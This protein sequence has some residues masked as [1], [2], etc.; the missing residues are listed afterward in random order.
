VVGAQA[1]RQ[2]GALRVGWDNLYRRLQQSKR[3]ILSHDGGAA[4][5]LM[6]A[7]LVALMAVALLMGTLLAFRAGAP[8]ADAQA[9]RVSSSASC[10]QLAATDPTITN[11]SSWGRT[12]LR[13]H[14]APGGWFGVDVCSNGFNS[15]S[16]NSSNVSCDSVGHGCS[17]TNDGYGWTFQCPELIVRFSAWAFGD[18]PADWGRSG[19]GNAPDL[20]LPANHPSDFVMYRNGSSTAPVPGDILIWGYLDGRGNPFPAGPDG[21]HGG[22]IAVV[23]SVH[24]GIVTTAEQNVKWGSEDH[25][26]DTLALKKVGSRWILSGSA[27]PSRTLPTWRWLNTMGHSRGTYG[28]LHNVKN[29]GR[30]PAKHTSSA[31][32]AKTTTASS[33]TVSNQFPGGLPSL[34]MATVITRSGTLADLT[35]STQS[36]FSPSSDGDQQEA[37]VR[38]LGTP[39]D[40]IHLASGQSAATLLL[41]DGSRYTYA[42]GT[43]GNLYVAR[44]SPTSFGVFWSTL[45]QPGGVS[46]TG[47]PVASL[48]AGGVQVAA[49]G[50]DGS[51]WWRAGP[52]DRPGSWFSLGSPSASPLSGSVALAGEPGSGMPIVF[53][54]GADGR[55]YTR[56]WQD[57]MVAADGTQI[58]A[59]WSDWLTLGAQSGV[60]QF[61]GALL[62]VPELPT[63][64]NWIGPWPD[65]PLNV[66]AADSAGQLWWLRSTHLSTGWTATAVAGGP[67]PLSA[68]YGAVAVPAAATSASAA[69][70]D[71]I[72][73]YA[74]SQQASYL[75]TL[76]I[77][78]AGA[79]GAGA[80]NAP[81]QPSNPTWT[82]LAAPPAGVTA[83]TVGAAVALGPGNSVLVAAAGDDVVIG[84]VKTMTAAM[85]P[86]AAAQRTGAKQPANPWMRVGAVPAAATFSDPFTATSLDS[87]WTRSDG[88]ARVTLD[89]KGL[90]LAPGANGV[91][92][93]M[94][95]AAPGDV[96]LSVQVARPRT[97]P[98]KAGVGLALYQDD[99]D[100]LTLTVDRTGAINLCASLRQAV[101]PCVTSKTKANPK[102][103]VWLEV[104]RSDSFYTA[105]WS[106]DGR[107]WQQI[108]QWTPDITSVSPSG[109]TRTPTGTPTATA[110][111]TPQGT[112]TAGAGAPTTA[113]P[114]AAPLAFTSW[115]VLSIGKGSASVWPHLSGFAVTPAP[116][117]ATIPAMTPTL[118]PA[119]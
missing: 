22:H 92:A 11:G 25:P 116:A 111:A 21:S 119:P 48:F 89:G 65:S 78:S 8:A 109:A 59:S 104:Q 19:W 14:G 33:K 106:A 46:L 32:A 31:T 17:P 74:A 81:A 114:A 67:A 76:V 5:Y 97:L 107:T 42:L 70:V 13:G 66:F 83:S 80:Q 26:S 69:S 43:D 64:H 23:A 101:Q 4:P 34:S 57:A 58:P 91:A 100:W 113:D 102:A 94:Q 90:A 72:A 24:G 39:P 29:N 96:A 103:T 30:F 82:T 93:L 2:E 55:L 36:F 3:M 95:A 51:L 12:I 6:R 16:P 98:D 47:S 49:R 45:G 41:S 50:S 75:C 27:Q 53:A 38:S 118:T 60:G 7:S 54:L 71:T 110:T 117:T 28:W 115:G 61:T 105:L 87:R 37:Q 85:L 99:G 20:W 52:P 40:G 35:W 9:L 44:T 18:S 63:A 73:L 15:V 112:A 84:G 10:A 1:G 56:L 79:S 86:S 68:L 62:V 77:P 88:G 108:A